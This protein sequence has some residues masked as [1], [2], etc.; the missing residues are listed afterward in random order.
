MKEV[1]LLVSVILLLAYLFATHDSPYI[2]IRKRP[3]PI[4]SKRQIINWYAWRG[5][6]FVEDFENPTN[7][8]SD[9]SSCKGNAYQAE[10]RKKYRKD[11]EDCN[12]FAMSWCRVPP[13]TSQQSWEQEYHNCSYWMR[14]PNEL[15]GDPGNFKQCTNNNLDNPNHLKFVNQGRWDGDTTH[16][17]SMA[18]NVCYKRNLDQCMRK[19]GHTNYA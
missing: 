19:L 2:P 1:Y 15:T 6:M 14:G 16:P 12:R 5:P 17:T 13:L 7:L 4:G 3:K 18:S 8:P 10:K 11:Y 9:P